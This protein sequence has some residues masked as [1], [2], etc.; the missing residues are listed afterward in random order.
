VVAQASAEKLVAPARAL[1]PEV[2]DVFARHAAD[3]AR[4]AARLG[5]PTLDVEDV[6]QEVFLKAHQHLPAWRSGGG[7]VTTWLFRA[8]RN[9][10]RHQ[11]R[12]D[13]FWPWLKG[14]AEDAAGTLPSPAPGPAELLEQQQQQARFYRVLEQLKEK[15]RTVLVLFELEAL[16]GDEIAT[17]MDAK[18]STVW[19]WLHRA[20]AEFLG[21]M[22]QLEKEERPV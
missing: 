1:A 13:R 10:V 19:V 20:R 2:V 21:R 8:T 17:M 5:G 18:V 7:A 14:S 6:V 22:Q 9:V 3:V 15:H 12:R 11:R 4:W 16:S